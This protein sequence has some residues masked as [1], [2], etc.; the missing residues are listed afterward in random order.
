VAELLVCSLIRYPRRLVAENL[1]DCHATF[2]RPGQHLRHHLLSELGGAAAI[3]DLLRIPVHLLSLQGN[4][5]MF[6][7]LSG[8]VRGM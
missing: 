2:R 6:I 1:Y 3:L 4:T 5:R 8:V 7:S